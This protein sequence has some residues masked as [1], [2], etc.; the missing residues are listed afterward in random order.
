MDD[1][2]SE[3]KVYT[4]DNLWEYIDG[5]AESYLSYGFQ[6]LRFCD[7]S[8]DGLTVTVHVYDM[9][10]R[11][12]AFGIYDMERPDGTP[13]LA[14]GAEAVVLPPY[15]CLLLK[16]RYYVK[17]DAFEGEI[18]EAV[19]KQ[20]LE[21]VAEA[22]PGAD[23]FP[24]ALVWLP[25]EGKVPDS[26]GFVKEG[27]LGLTDLRNCVHADYVGEGDHRYQIF[28]MI[29][30]AEEDVESVWQGLGPKWEGKAHGDYSVRFREVP[31]RGFVGVVI[32]EKGIFGASDAE[33]E[34]ELMARL[35]RVV[36][37]MD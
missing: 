33:S 25:V 9:G 37:G 27:Y 23:G 11:L 35:E 10:S 20:L 7:L 16:D 12:N 5:A 19:G 6:A 34:E 29:P 36:A 31:Y 1:A 4:P 18:T 28:V 2:V 32:T 30:D 8:G 24:E 3:V 13:R 14:V 26:E 21:A 22:L 15:Q 17:I